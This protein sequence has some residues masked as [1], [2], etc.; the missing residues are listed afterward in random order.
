MPFYYFVCKT[1]VKGKLESNPM[2]CQS[3]PVFVNAPLVLA[4]CSRGIC[5]LVYSSK[6]RHR[7]TGGE[8]CQCVC[9]CVCVA[10]SGQQFDFDVHV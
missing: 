7:D 1:L 5:L 3:P 8:V 9:M 6:S 2:F 4:L 10:L